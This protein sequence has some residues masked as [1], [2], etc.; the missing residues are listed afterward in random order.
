MRLL[1]AFFF[2]SVFLSKTCGSTDLEPSKFL[3]FGLGVDPQLA[4]ITLP[5]R[6]FY[7]QLVNTD[8]TNATESPDNGFIRVNIDGLNENTC[9]AWA[10]AIDRYDGSFLVRYRLYNS[11]SKGLRITITTAKG[12]PVAQSPY[13][14]ERPV[15]YDG[16]DCAITAK[17]FLSTYQC[18]KPSKTLRDSLKP[19]QRHSVNFTWVVDEVKSRFGKYPG[20]YS[21]C[22]YVIKQNRIYRNCYGQHV[23]FKMF[24]DA[25]LLSLTRKVTL[26]DMEFFINLGDWPL[27][28]RQESPIPILSWCGSE[29]TYDIILPTYDVTES[30]LEA[31]G[32]QSLDMQSVQGMAKPTWKEK[33]SKAF[34]RGRDS[35]QERLDLVE[36]SRSHPDL[37]DAGL[38]NFFF[39]RDQIDRYGPKVPHVSFGDFFKYKVSRELFLS[40]FASIT[41]DFYLLQYQVNID[42]TVA[43][44]RFPYLLASNSL[45]LKQDSDYYEWFYHELQP[46]VHYVPV[47]RDLSDLIE[48]INWAKAND[49]K[50][51]EIVKNAQDFARKHLQ[52]LEIFCSHVRTLLGYSR[53]LAAEPSDPGPDFELVLQPEEKEICDCPKT[54]TSVVGGVRTEL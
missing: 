53:I 5:V 15:R 25:I 19:W 45:V 17:E 22:H 41:S 20:A 9:R 33:I 43:A 30:T 29:E 44:Y 7:V 11:C 10:Q 23:G 8:G 42:G 36:M 48:K 39:F 32:R 38:T 28:K 18:P 46:W 40:K 24:S 3:V 2:L 51:F 54:A 35:R 26:P 49:Q 21:L 16:C 47:K 6:Y 12:H 27:E 4:S 14:I 50:A 37:I 31:L 52:P 1:I 13:L 34:W